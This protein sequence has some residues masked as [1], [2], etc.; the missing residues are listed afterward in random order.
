M[1]RSIRRFV[2]PARGA[3]AAHERFRPLPEGDSVAER[4]HLAFGEPDHRDALMGRALVF[5]QTDR[6]DNAIAELSYL[7]DFSNRILSADDS[8]GR[9]VLA[10]AYANRGIVHDRAGHHEKAFAD[11]VAALRTDEESVDEPGW[12][13]KVLYGIPKPSSVR[14]RAA[15]L[16]EQFKLPPEQRL[17]RV[18]AI[19]ARQRMRKP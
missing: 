7:I 8:T 19:D 14:K 6:H 18:P 3:L 17:L 2:E 5:I 11:Y 16:Q 13:H 1:A 15:Y 10:A 9:G 4:R 12:I